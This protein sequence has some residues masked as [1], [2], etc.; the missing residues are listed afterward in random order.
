VRA[1]GAVVDAIGR[2]KLALAAGGT[3][4]AAGANDVGAEVIGL[5]SAGAEVLLVAGGAALTAGCWGVLRSK[6]TTLAVMMITTL[7]ETLAIATMRG[8]GMRP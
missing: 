4:D 5:G 6:T 7:S 3:D 8:S 1:G 2:G